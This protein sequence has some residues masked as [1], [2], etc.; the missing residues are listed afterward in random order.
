MHYVPY[1]HLK[2][3]MLWFSLDTHNQQRYF[4]TCGLKNLPQVHGKQAGFPGSTRKSHVDWK[5]T[6]AT[7]N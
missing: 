3:K 4:P 7:S 5:I 1:E 6:P 2:Y